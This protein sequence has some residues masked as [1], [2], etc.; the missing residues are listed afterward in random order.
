MSLQFFRPQDN[1]Y[2]FFEAENGKNREKYEAGSERGE[3]TEMG[4]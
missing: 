1:F 2:D 4:L 3:T